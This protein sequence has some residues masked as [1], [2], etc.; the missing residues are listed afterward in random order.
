MVAVL[1]GGTWESLSETV[2]LRKRLEADEGRATEIPVDSKEVKA[3]AMGEHLRSR[4][5]KEPVVVKG[6]TGENNR[7]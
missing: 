4:K 7:R 1:N 5:I 6:K 2:I 3:S